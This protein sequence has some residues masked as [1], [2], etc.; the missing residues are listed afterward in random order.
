M[1]DHVVMKKDT[2]AHL[3]QYV[4]WNIEQKLQLSESITLASSFKGHFGTAML[5]GILA[6]A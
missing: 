3:K 5:D 6:F 4:K 2:S 1:S